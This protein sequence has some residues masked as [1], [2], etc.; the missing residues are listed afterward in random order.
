MPVTAS[1]ERRQSRPRAKPAKAQ[2][3]RLRR[4]SPP[5]RLDLGADRRQRRRATSC[6]RWSCIALL[7]VV[8]Q[9]ALLGAR[10]LAAAADRRSG[11]R[12]SDLIA[13]PVLRLRLAGYR[14]RPGACSISLQRVAIG[15][16]LAA[17]VGVALGALVGQ[18]VWAMRGLDPIFQ[19][20][21]T[22]PPLAWLP[23]SLAAFRDS[24]ALGDLRDL[25]HRR[26]GR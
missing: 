2:R 18:S 14:A 3:R 7:L 25:H 5:R 15:F 1:A 10:R 26:S 17:V 9:I 19:I 23:L 20:L 24:A 13:D 4:P 16:G 12:A 22:V 8:W 21:R 6:R 11:A